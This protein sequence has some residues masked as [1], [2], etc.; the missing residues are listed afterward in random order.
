MARQGITQFEILSGWKEIA[1]YL[2]GGVRTVQRYECELG[3]PI[4]RPAGRS[5]GSVIATKA[6]IDAWISA[7][8]LREAF[9]LSLHAMDSTETVKGLKQQVTEL[10]RL[11]EET[12]QLRDEMSASRKA[13]KASIHL[14]R[15]SLALTTEDPQ[16]FS[17]R[18][19]ADVLTF[20][21]QRKVN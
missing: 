3:L 9:R 17:R 6:E 11:R 7:S 8:P 1:N 5:R 13:L 10:H 16:L 14:L 21:P 15:E 2:G 19:T 20:A 4:R 18:R 12:A